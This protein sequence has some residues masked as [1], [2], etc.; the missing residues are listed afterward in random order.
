MT[1]DLAFLRQRAQFVE[2]PDAFAIREATHLEPVCSGVDFGHIVDIVERVERKRP[3][4]HRLRI[5]R[6]HLVR[7]EQQ[8]LHIVV[9]ERHSAQHGVHRRVIGQIAA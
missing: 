7:I 6:G 1:R 9:E 3:C 4:D 8:G 5:G 2:R